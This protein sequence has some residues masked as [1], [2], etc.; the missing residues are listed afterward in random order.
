MTLLFDR[1]ISDSGVELA[2]VFDESRDAIG[3]DLDDVSP[4]PNQRNAFAWDAPLQ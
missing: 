4:H 1:L 2:R 3:D